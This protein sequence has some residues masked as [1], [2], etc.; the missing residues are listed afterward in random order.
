MTSERRGIGER[1][2]IPAQAPKRFERWLWVAIAVVTAA[3]LLPTLTPGIVGLFHDDAI[4]ASG[5]RLL[6]EGQ[7]YRLPNLPDSPYQT[8]YPPLFAAFLAVVWWIRPEFPGNILFLKALNLGFIAAA[9]VA[10][11]RLAR[12]QNQKISWTIPVACQLVLATNPTLVGLANYTMT[13]VLFTTLVVSTVLLWGRS[14]ASMPVWREASVVAI[15]VAAM[16]TRSVGVALAAAIAVDCLLRRQRARAALHGGVAFAVLSAWMLWSSAHRVGISP[17]I[18]YYQEYE[19]PAFS[20][21]MTSPGLALQIVGGNM[22]LAADSMFL[23]VGPFW[24]LMWPLLL[25]LMAVG[26]FQLARSGWRMPILFAGC[27]LA[28]VISHPWTPNRYLLPLVPLF[29]LAVVAGAIH[30]W[31]VVRPS[32]GALRRPGSVPALIVLGALLFSN[33]L[34]LRYRLRP[35]TTVREWAGSDLG[36]RWSGFEDTF[37]W[38]RRNTPPDARLGS[39][40]DTMYFL[41]TGRQGVRPWFHRSDTYFYPYGAARPFVGKPGDVARELRALGVDYLV[42]DPPTGFFEGPAAMA[43]LQELVALSD[44][45]ARLV[46][47]SPDGLHR[48][49][50]LWNAEGERGAAAG[51]A[52]SEPWASDR[53]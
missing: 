16:L 39:L 20:Y 53:R 26:A 25:L 6:A 14:G 24:M 31:A 8:K 43:L 34:W 32:R 3:A 11:A 33:G 35:E 52:R 7:G 28:L 21:L 19:R 13:D 49:Y 40:F 44:V 38:I 27:Y 51:L 10:I 15:S 12:A 50:R 23:V 4:Y 42:L 37:E 47:R 45:N 5:A 48:V 29:I 36:Y 18:A 30:L 9:A 46:F 41:Y 17:L 2:P 22:R 1:D